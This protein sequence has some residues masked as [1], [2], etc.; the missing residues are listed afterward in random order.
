M[1][2]C[3][4][5]RLFP[6]SLA[7]VP[8]VASSLSQLSKYFWS[9]STKEFIFQEPWQSLQ[10]PHACNNFHDFL[11]LNVGKGCIFSW[12]HTVV[13]MYSCSCFHSIYSGKNQSL[14]YPFSD[15]KNWIFN[16]R[17][18]CKI[19]VCRYNF[20]FLFPLWAQQTSEVSGKSYQS[21]NSDM[22]SDIWY[23]V[24]RKWLLLFVALFKSPFIAY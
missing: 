10:F 13:T 5:G 12:P 24:V 22:I 6:Q 8:V 7:K 1:C 17:I 15:I 20:F 18:N 19:A 23:H 11:P 2:P 21:D 3:V 16:V 14:Q 4:C 9:L